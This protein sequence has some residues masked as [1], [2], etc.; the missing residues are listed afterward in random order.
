M[1]EFWPFL[2]GGFAVGGVATLYPLLTGRLLGVSSIYASA[3]ERRDGLGSDLDEL[4]AQ[5]LAA[6]EAEF[7]KS[8]VAP[9]P[10]SLSERLDRFRAETERFRPLF[11]VGLPLGAALATLAS[12]GFSF[13]LTLGQRFDAR[14]GE[15]GPLSVLVLLAS[16]LL[17]GVGTRVGAGCTSG[18]GISGVAR[19]EKASLLTTS[20]FWGTAL[21]VAWLFALAGVR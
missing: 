17:I 5:L 11:L 14:Y 18:H 12:G 10:P 8:E 16:G 2:V 19:G 15:F 3:F 13:D 6:T 9:G 20:V 21:G 4:E 7:G 1:S